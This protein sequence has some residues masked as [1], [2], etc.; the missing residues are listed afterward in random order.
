MDDT[1]SRNTLGKRRRGRPQTYST[2]KAK[3]AAD[4]K[5]KRAARQ[6]ASSAKRDIAHTSFYNPV[7][8]LQS[9]S[10][11]SDFYPL[12]NPTDVPQPDQRDISQFLA[13]VDPQLE[14]GTEEQAIF[15]AGTPAGTADSSPVLDCN[16]P[17]PDEAISFNVPLESSPQPGNNEPDLA[18]HLAQKLAEQLI[19]FHGCCDDCHQA[20]KQSRME[21]P[22]AQ[23]SLALYLESTIGLGAD[24]LS[25]KTLANQKDDLAGKLNPEC[26]KIFCGLDFRA[27][28][29]HI[30]LDKDESVSSGACVTFDVD[31]IIGFPSSLA[32]AKRDIRWSPTRMTVS[33]LQSDLHLRSFPVTYFDADG[34][35]HQVHRPVHQVPHYTFGRVIGFE[36]ISLYLLFPKLYRAEQKSSRLRDEDFQLWMDGILLPAIYQSYSS[37]H[38]QH[39]PSSYNHSRYNST[40][41]GVETLTQHVHPV[42]R[43]QQLVYCLPP[44][45][46]ADIWTGILSATQK[47]GFHQF[48]DV[49]ILLQAKNLKTITKDTTWEKM[50]SRFEEYWT[51]SVDESHVTTDFYID[52]GKETCPRQISKVASWIQPVA[53]ENSGLEEIQAET[54]LYKRCCLESYSSQVIN[55]PYEYIQIK[56]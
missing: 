6:D 10:T 52:V 16:G 7:P 38:V 55:S 18:G 37:A 36:D 46:L 21:S 11:F 42:A 24:V 43:E 44:E 39:Y 26:R 25:S 31:S 30:C 56:L 5:R 54:L 29:P 47:P 20:A 14:E 32:V 4:V 17:D 1:R 19:K 9:A 28:I 3:A 41:R 12:A 51:N 13:E 35:Q 50:A 49:T 33:D 27:E 45:P 40:A 2:P 53:E 34:V 15:D 8:S 23:I 22:N 48:Q